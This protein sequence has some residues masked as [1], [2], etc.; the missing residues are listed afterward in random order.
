[1]KP[2]GIHFWNLL[3]LTDQYGSYLH[4]LN[5][6]R[7][8]QCREILW[9]VQ[10]NSNLLISILYRSFCILSLGFSILVTQSLPDNIDITG[11]ETGVVPLPENIHSAWKQEGF[12]H[13]TKVTA[14]NGGS[15]HIAAQE[16]ISQAQIIRSRNVLEHFLTDFPGS[17]YGDDKSAVVNAMADNEAILLLLNGRDDGRNEPDLP[18]QWLFEEE[19]TVEGSD[20]YMN[21]V[22]EG[23]RDATFEEILHL[24]H[25][26]GIGVDGHNS[27]PG[28]LS[29]YQVE[30]RNATDHAMAN[31]YQIWPM[32]AT[33]NSDIMNWVNE[34][35]DENSLT[36]EYLAS[37][38]DS[39]YGLWGAWEEEPDKGM[40]GLYIAHD[41]SEIKTEDPMGWELMEMF[42]HPYLQ[43]IAWVDSSFS[44]TFAINFDENLPYTHASQYLLKV[45]LNGSQNTNLVGNDQ[46]NVLVGNR[47]DNV[48]DGREG[49]DSVMFRGN[50]SDYSIETDEGKTVVKDKSEQIDG[51]DSLISVEYLVFRDK[52]IS[53]AKLSNEGEPKHP[54]KFGLNHSYPNPFNPV[55]TIAYDLPEKS[56]VNLS[57][58]NI[59]GTRIA[60]LINGS[61]EAGYKKAV[62]DGTDDFG[63]MV[64][65]GVYLVHIKVGVYTETRKMLFL[66]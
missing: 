23:H 11:T 20:W 29:E 9:G 54:E 17:K 12:V 66:K 49:V 4:G 50:Y 33:S 35:D 37:V 45:R 28:A 60:T 36:Q 1:M 64:S 44:G 41:R 43:Y 18:G 59:M 65:G 55:T 46:G 13:Y 40:W 38:I 21:N 16:A 47:G 42:F 26:A 6:S 34:L 53:T 52:T 48:I 27:M 61:E 63:R 30:I 32:G 2:V 51:E 24:V 5:L 14:P 57:I 56:R 58:Y 10:T 25:D 39:Y 7:E 62:W 19:L 3:R 15:I 8:T 31:D 22:Y